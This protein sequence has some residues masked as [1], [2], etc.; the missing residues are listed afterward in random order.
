MGSGRISLMIAALSLWHFA[1]AQ[2]ELP[3]NGDNQRSE[4]VQFMGLVKV[5]IVYS[6][7]RVRGR[8]IWGAVV[9]YGSTNFNVGNSTE[10]NPSPWRAGANENTV[11]TF[12][13]DVQ[14]EGKTLRAGTYGLHMIPGSDEWTVIFS[15]N[16]NSW[17]SFFY[18]PAE[19]ALRVTVKPRNS[20]F[21]EWL[22]YEFTDRLQNSSTML[23]SWERISVPVMITV[24]DGD[25][26][27]FQ[28]LREQFQGAMGPQGHQFMVWQNWV[29]A[30]NFCARKKIH[31]EEAMSWLDIYLNRGA[32]YYTLLQAKSNLLVA[33]GRQGEADALMKE[34]ATLSDAGPDQLTAYGQELL[35]RNLNKEAMEVFLLNLDRH[36]HQAGALMGLAFG[37]SRNGDTKK[38]LKFATEAL[39]LEKN[40]TRRTQIELAI[41][42][43][44]AGQGI[45]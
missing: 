4:V 31:L 5:T 30:A 27:Y 15:N 6:S 35:T 13:H 36:P 12:S 20:E 24:P 18:T 45:N 43:L 10:Q 8:E 11:I 37:Y 41:K 39:A 14:V 3:P 34:A 21:N 29:Q 40:E 22:T 28:R 23:M 16:S 42:Q 32:K 44:K 25:E 38:A 33:M 17:G 19:D 9:P 7:P 26:I 2:P 1:T